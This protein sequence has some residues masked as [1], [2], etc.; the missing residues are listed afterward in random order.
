MTTTNTLLL[1]VVYSEEDRAS[2]GQER[3]DRVR[4]DALEDMGHDV[5]TLDDKHSS[6][7]VKSCR[8]CQANFGDARRM[9]KLMTAQWGFE[10]FDYIIL[11][12]FFSP[13]GWARER[14]SAT[15]FKE[16]LVAFAENKRL[17]KHGVIIL[18]NLQPVREGLELHED[19]I[20]QYYQ[21]EFMIDARENPLYVATENCATYLFKCPGKLTNGNQ[22][23]EEHGFSAIPFYALRVKAKK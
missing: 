14:W 3:R 23:T 22:L 2:I 8:H 17:K 19:L 16:T 13:V 18:P 6:E 12:Y 7:D 10:A 9:I 21:W 11:D 5:Y 20:K 1:G 15:F 4:C